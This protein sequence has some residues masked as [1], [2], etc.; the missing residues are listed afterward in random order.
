MATTMVA[1]VG[2]NIALAEKFLPLLDEIYKRESLTSILDTAEARV[3]WT[4]ADTVNLFDIDMVGLGDYSR[5]SG[6]VRAMLTGLG[7]PTNWML[8]VVVPSL[9]T[10]WTT[11]RLLE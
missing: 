4:G 1:P 11:K 9:L 5:N 6:Y 3:Q 10:I 2:N 7:I 8:I